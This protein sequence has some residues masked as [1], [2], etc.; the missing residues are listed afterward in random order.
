MPYDIKVILALRNVTQVNLSG[1]DTFTGVIRTGEELTKRADDAATA[2]DHYDLRI[3]PLDS[4]IILRIAPS[5]DVL[6][7]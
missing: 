7:A 6:N 2:T 3:I 5:L 4:C 1:Q